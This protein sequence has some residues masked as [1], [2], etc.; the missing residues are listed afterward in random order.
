MHREREI[1]QADTMP[2]DIWIKLRS[3]DLLSGELEHRLVS[4][5]MLLLSRTGG[6]RLTIDVTEYTL[7]PDTAY[8]I[9]PGQTIG[10]AVHDKDGPELF[11]FQYD[12][13]RDGEADHAFP[14]AGE[15]PIYPEQQIG[16]LCEL[17]YGSSRHDN[18]LERFRG[19]S[20]FQE[21]LY[22]IAKQTRRRTTDSRAAIDRTKAYI[23]SHYGESITIDQLARMAEISSKYYV[24]LFKRTYGLSA[25]DYLTEVR[26]TAA[27]R[28]M[29]RS[30]ALLRNIAQQVG[31]GDE[32]YF[33]RKFKQETGVS[34]TVYMK[35]RRR[36]IAVYSSPILGH[37][38]ALDIIPYA[39]PLHPKWTAHYYKLF[40]SDIPLHL[41]A[42]RY[43][44]HWESNLAKLA[45]AAPDLILGCDTLTGGEKDQLETIAPVVYV[46]YKERGWREQLRITAEAVD[47][48]REAEM[49]MQRY[50]SKV[51]AAKRRLERQ[52][53]GQRVVAMSL[54]QQTIRLSPTAGMRD[55]LYGDLAL[56]P[57][58]G[59]DPGRKGEAIT[60]DGL[61]AYDADRIMLNIC[62]EPESLAEWERLQQLPEWL[63]IKAV[64]SGAVTLIASDP[65]REYS[66]SACE[67]MVDDMVNKFG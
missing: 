53:G 1:L 8:F 23:D 45:A 66:A 28:L 21:L 58:A 6:G 46:P 35:N 14:Y 26:V 61:A 62:Q 11:A 18:S 24:D 27:K 2:D 47:A 49:W 55:V 9:C 33:S 38:L 5:H 42:Y 30:G 41:S 3:T 67:R 16:A 36:K 37:L 48:T 20:A 19:Q 17:V 43:N 34:P 32:F 10:V 56:L 57:P 29:A 60:L 65:W 39:A 13:F 7:R 4:S 50:E 40:K 15:V 64:R 63:G 59:I 31:Y 44:M 54:F 12:V 51:T 22:W 52:L 25:I